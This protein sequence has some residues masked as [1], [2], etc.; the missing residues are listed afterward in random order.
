MK[1]PKRYPELREIADNLA[2]KFCAE[3][4]QATA[5][6]KSEMPYKFQWVLEEV[7]RELQARV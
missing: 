1:Q 3:I 7:A 5:G 2:N 6:V 4:N